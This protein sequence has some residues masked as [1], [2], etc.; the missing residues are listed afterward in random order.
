MNHCTQNTVALG[1]FSDCVAD[2]KKNLCVGWLGGR[3]KG[4]KRAESN[5]EDRAKNVSFTCG[6]RY[7]LTDLVV[8]SC[9]FFTPLRRGGA[10]PRPEEVPN[11]AHGRCQNG[12]AHHQPLPAAAAPAT[13]MG[14]VSTKAPQPQQP[15][16][17]PR[18]HGAAGLPGN[19]IPSGIIR[20]GYLA[21]VQGAI[22]IALGIWAAVHQ[23][24]AGSNTG[25]EIADPAKEGIMSTIGYGTAVFL[26]IV[27]GAIAAGGWALT[28]GRRWGRA[29]VVMMELFTLPIAYYMIKAGHPLWALPV[30]VSG[31]VGLA[32]LF[33]GRSVE[34]A[35]KGFG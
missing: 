10:P 25:L 23:M 16:P 34:W 11:P 7:D 31:L 33:N 35:A 30:G 20:V 5:R 1:N 2:H 18:D 27:F 6:D 26:L 9:A 29:P 22:G 8:V 32:W 17:G 21:M 12:A 24:M 13:T 3:K 14:T 15:Q 4:R 19:Y 28:T